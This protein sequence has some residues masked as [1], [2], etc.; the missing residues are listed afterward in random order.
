MTIKA[1]LRFLLKR[2]N[3]EIVEGNICCD[4]KE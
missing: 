4:S 2:L 3:L 1:F